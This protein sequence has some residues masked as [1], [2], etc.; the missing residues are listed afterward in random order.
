MPKM[1]DEC[2]DQGPTGAILTGLRIFS[3]VGIECQTRGRAVHGARQQATD[4]R[5]VGDGGGRDGPERSG[6]KALAWAPCLFGR[7]A[8]C[9]R[10]ARCPR[11]PRCA[12]G[13]Q[14]RC[15][16]RVPGTLRIFRILRCFGCALFRG[17]IRLVRS[18][19]V[20]ARLVRARLVRARLVRARLVRARLVRARLVRATFVGGACLRPS[21]VPV[22]RRIAVRA[23]VS[24]PFGGDAAG[25]RGN[26]LPHR[27]QP[28]GI[29]LLWLPGR[30]AVRHVHQRH[31]HTATGRAGPAAG[32]TARGT[33]DVFH[34]A[35]SP[36]LWR[37]A[38]RRSAFRAGAAVRTHPAV[39]HHPRH[40]RPCSRRGSPAPQ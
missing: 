39:H 4:L 34:L 35:P 16:S 36:G 33:A 2:R 3:G 19:P 32:R 21:G 27:R 11:C 23:V 28:G 40:H 10:C 6:A 25:G 13:L 1:P 17:V 5:T 15:F 37:G 31:R 7:P 29:R 30:G 20:R 38:R 22:L 24:V 18:W 9:A 12:Q 8:R 14:F 26:G